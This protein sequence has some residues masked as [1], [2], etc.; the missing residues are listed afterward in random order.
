M[1]TGEHDQHVCPQKFKKTGWAT[2]RDVGAFVQPDGVTIDSAEPEVSA[3]QDANHKDG[4]DDAKVDGLS[5][6]ALLT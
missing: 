5:M 1:A 2:E 4:S 3:E 6:V